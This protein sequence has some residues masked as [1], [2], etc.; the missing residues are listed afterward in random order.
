MLGLRCSAWVFSSCGQQGLLSALS[1]WSSPSSGF[2]C[3][4]WALEC[5]G[6]VVALRH[7]ES[8]RTGMEHL[9]WQADYYPLYR[10]G[11]PVV[12]FWMVLVGEGTNV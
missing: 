3:R 5:A 7:V 11:S 1:A 2:S 10:Q 8:S 6:S 9:H 12:I 4:E